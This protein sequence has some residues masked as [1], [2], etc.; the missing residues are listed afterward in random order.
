MLILVL[1]SVFHVVPFFGEGTISYLYVR[2]R[3]GWEV[4]EYSNYRVADSV[5]SI[6]G[7]YKSKFPIIAN[8][9]NLF[10]LL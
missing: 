5:T 9:Y 7:K 3:F 10:L 8:W 1:L 6:V 4:D 2:T